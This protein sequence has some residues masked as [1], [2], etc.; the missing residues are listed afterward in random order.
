MGLVDF[1]FVVFQILP[2]YKD[3]LMYELINPLN[4]T[5]ANMHLILTLT[6]NCGIE[7]VS[8]S[9]LCDVSDPA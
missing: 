9:C 5:R 2:D 4:A 8:Y 7:R 6:E 1:L 3:K